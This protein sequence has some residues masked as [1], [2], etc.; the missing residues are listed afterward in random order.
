MDKLNDMNT[1][2]AEISKELDEVAENEFTEAMIDAENMKGVLEMA[3]TFV[4][5]LDDFPRKIDVETGYRAVLSVLSVLDTTLYDTYKRL[6]ALNNK[7][8]E[9]L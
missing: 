5:Y 4:T 6:A 1:R 7:L 8:R 3:R 9:I 2:L